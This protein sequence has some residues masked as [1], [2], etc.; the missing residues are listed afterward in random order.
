MPETTRARQKLLFGEVGAAPKRASPL[1]AELLEFCDYG[2][3]S[4]LASTSAPLPDGGEV[5]VDT[6]VGEFWTSGQR[7]G[8]S[9]HEVSYRACFKPQLPAFFVDRLSRPGEVVYDPF[10][11]RGTTLLEAALR[12]RV[13]A[14]CDINPLSALLIRPRLRPPTTAE[15]EERLQGLQL[16]HDDELPEDLLVFYHPETLAE[17]MAL[18][19][20]FDERTR[21]GD[22]DIVDEWI[23]MVA[24]GRLTGHSTG[25]FSVYTL[26]PNQA[27]SVES[28]RKINARRSQEPPRRDVSA[29]IARK[30]ASLLKGVSDADRRMLGRAADRSV[31]LS[32]RAEHTPELADGSVGLVVTSPPFLDVV[33]YSDDNWL[34]CWFCGIDSESVPITMARTVDR[35]QQAMQPVF[36]EM[37][38]VLRPGGH[39]AFEVGEVRK[40]TVRLEEAVIPV[41]LAAGF[42]VDLVVIHSQHFTKTANCWGVGN[43]DKGTNSNRIVVA[44]KPD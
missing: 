4:V 29:L 33:Q 12:G 23:R 20:Y 36:A 32:G 19:G 7:R 15:V 22:L 14:G 2:R 1:L 44:R 6:V 34:R 3:R 30:S 38:R 37:F 26:P 24:I 40:G 13:P 42:D 9:L 17:L 28:Q 43:N 25:F 8:H 31:V 18:R 16:R 27:V 39:V 41:A 11:G 35:W 10:A 5:E 21:R